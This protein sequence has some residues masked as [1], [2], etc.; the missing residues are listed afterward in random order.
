MTIHLNPTPRDDGCW[1]TFFWQNTS[2]SL[3]RDIIDGNVET[4]L[5]R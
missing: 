3:L 1:H 4:T 2:A 5:V